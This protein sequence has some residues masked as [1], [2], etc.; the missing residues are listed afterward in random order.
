MAP[1]RAPR[2]RRCLRGEAAVLFY[3]SEVAVGAW[4]SRWRQRT[5]RLAALLRGLNVAEE[6]DALLAHDAAVA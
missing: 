2:A 5:D 6:V 1:S 4:Q 3:C